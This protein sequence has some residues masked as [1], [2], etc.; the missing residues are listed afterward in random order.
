MLV[1]AF[2]KKRGRWPKKASLSMNVFIAPDTW[3]M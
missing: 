3:N 1:N 2:P